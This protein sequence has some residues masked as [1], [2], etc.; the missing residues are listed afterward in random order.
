MSNKNNSMYNL[1]FGLYKLVNFYKQSI[2]IVKS[3]GLISHQK[4]HTL[5]VKIA[6]TEV[7]VLLGRSC[8]PFGEV[9]RSITFI[10]YH[11]WCT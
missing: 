3:E 7:L 4:S 11:T 1:I 9:K 10:K 6:T 5:F 2:C 8:F